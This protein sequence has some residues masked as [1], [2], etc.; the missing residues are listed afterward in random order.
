L[1]TRQF[2]YIIG[3]H[4]FGKSLI[5]NPFNLNINPSITSYE[6]INSSIYPSI[7]STDLFL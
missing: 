6:K 7:S 3:K 1:K 4:K 2:N 5:V